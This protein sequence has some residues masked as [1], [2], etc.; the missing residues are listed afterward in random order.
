MLGAPIVAIGQRT[1]AT[2]NDAD[3]ADEAAA[4]IPS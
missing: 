3:G 2:G 1:K 4:G